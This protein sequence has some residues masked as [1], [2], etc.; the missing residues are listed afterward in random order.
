MKKII[1]SRFRF[2]VFENIWLLNNFLR[3]IQNNGS[4]LHHKK[5]TYFLFALDFDNINVFAN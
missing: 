2:L 3:F 5:K 4:K 1:A